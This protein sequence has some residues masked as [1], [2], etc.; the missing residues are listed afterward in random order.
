MDAQLGVPAPAAAPP[1]PAHTRSVAPP[2]PPFYVLHAPPFYPT[3]QPH[4]PLPQSPT[5][6][7]QPQ[8]VMYAL[9]G[10]APAPPTAQLLTHAALHEQ[11]HAAA[12]PSVMGTAQG[13][14]SFSLGLHV[15]LATAARVLV[16]YVPLALCLLAALGVLIGTFFVPVSH[17][18]TTFTRSLQDTS[19]PSTYPYLIDSR[20][21]YSRWARAP[22]A[23]CTV[24]KQVACDVVTAAQVSGWMGTITG[25]MLAPYPELLNISGIAAGT[26]QSCTYVP[27]AVPQPSSTAS[28]SGSAGGAHASALLLPAA[29]D[30]RD[31]P[32]PQLA[33]AGGHH[34][35]SASAGVRAVRAVS[36]WEESLF[37]SPVYSPGDS[38]VSLSIHSSDP[39][40]AQARVALQCDGDKRTAPMLDLTTVDA[41]NVSAYLSEEASAAGP[42]IVDAD[43][44]LRESP[45]SL[46]MDTSQL[47]PNARCID[48]ITNCF[49]DSSFYYLVIAP[50]S[51][52][53][54]CGQGSI[55]SQAAAPNASQLYT[56]V[57]CETSFYETDSDFTGVQRLTVQAAFSMNVTLYPTKA[58]LQHSDR[59]ASFALPT[60][61]TVAIP[62][63]AFLLT[64]AALVLVAAG[65]I[66][67]HR[68]RLRRLA[69]ALEKDAAV[70]VGILYRAQG[71]AMP[72]PVPLPADAA[73]PPT[74]PASPTAS[75][76]PAPPP[77]QQPPAPPVM[78]APPY[79][80]PAGGPMAGAPGM[81]VLVGPPQPS[82]ADRP[83]PP[84]QRRTPRRAA[85]RR[86]RGRSAARAVAARA[87]WRT[88]TWSWSWSWSRALRPLRTAARTSWW[89][90]A[91]VAAPPC[92]RRRR[93]AP[94][95][96]TSPR[97]RHTSSRTLRAVSRCRRRRC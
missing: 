72:P 25:V 60:A 55:G 15:P 66:P 2:P 63:A 1:P 68:Q 57:V 94:A 78:F 61:S 38:F 37:S 65:H 85:P 18:H 53:Y 10:V 50:A 17:G 36:A 32:A 6:Q 19:N 22:Y 52:L 23:P 45:D 70:A 13:V 49:S 77:T 73:P 41:V 89:C 11:A 3:P 43:T 7:P 31:T 80:A 51:Q 5:P 33:G 24:F 96:R 62:G 74:V 76:A 79:Y 82:A 69:D 64:A 88:A 48:M 40:G 4:A 86:R 20:L 28:H 75:A 26:V 84:R 39:G 29:H 67:A 46:Q 91:A 71:A 87:W 56:V 93:A 30:G 35:V 97:T 16:F 90:G 8:P 81:M 42:P 54:P 47:Y 34:R 27:A 59:A 9:W 95:M 92:S 44:I 83:R 14:P 12:P 58:Q 21:G